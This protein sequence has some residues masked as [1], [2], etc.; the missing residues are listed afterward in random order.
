VGASLSAMI[1]L[2][3]AGPWVRYTFWG[4]AISVFFSSA[5]LVIVSRQDIGAVNRLTTPIAISS[6]SVYLT[7][8][9]AIDI[10][11]E[12]MRWFPETAWLAYFPIM[13]IIVSLFSIFFYFSIERTSIRIRDLYWPR[14]E[15]TAHGP[16]VT[17]RNVAA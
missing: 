6:Y 1:C 9:L 10:A 11:R 7:H 17:T 8:A 2:G 12:L 5:L 14:R 3:F 16:P 4:T 15:R 13:L